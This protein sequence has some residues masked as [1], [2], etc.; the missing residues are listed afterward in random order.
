MVVVV[1]VTNLMLSQRGAGLLP[2]EIALRFASM[3]VVFYLIVSLQG[4]SQ[5]QMALNQTI[6]FTDWVVAHSHLAMM[7]FATFASI[8]GIIHAWQRLPDARYNAKALEWAYWLLLIGISVMMIDLTIAGVIQGKL[9]QTSAPWLESIRVSGPYWLVRSLAAVPIAAGFILVL[10]GLTTGARGAGVHAI[11]QSLRDKPVDEVVP[12]TR[13][14]EGSG[15]QPARA[16]RGLVMSY[17]V[18]SIA[19]V[20]FFALSVSLLGAWPAS[21]L[22]EQSAAMAPPNPLPLTAAEER[23]RVIYAREGCAYCHSQQNTILA[24]GYRSI[25]CT[26]AGLGNT[27]RLP[28][29]DGHASHRTG[30]VPRR[31]NPHRELALRTS[32]RP[33]DGSCPSRSCRRMRRCSTGHRTGRRKRRVTSLPTSSP[34]ADRAN[35]HGR[36]VTRRPVPSPATIAGPV[37][38]SRHLCST[39]IPLAPAPE[40]VRLCWPGTARWSAARHSGHKTAGGCH[41]ATGQGDGPAA[42][43]LT[44]SPTNLTARDYTLPRMSDILWNGVH[45]T[46]MQAWRDL[47]DYDRAALAAQVASFAPG[48]D[49]TAPPDLLSRGAGIYSTHC[50]ECH[51]DDG[52]GNGFAAAELPIMPTDFAGERPTLAEAIGVLQNGVRGTS[53]APWTDRLSDDEITAVAHYVRRFYAGGG[54]TGASP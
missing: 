10:V 23:G 6:H 46:A 1:V 48:A 18:A 25:R 27:L 38:L 51:G 22:A 42:R 17:I 30:P 21:V 32:L 12:E 37:C 49:E 41:G 29:P 31:R 53:M 2:K 54:G 47:S 9:W 52:G 3:S 26:D 7:G 24:G 50:A 35:S 33:S 44:P 20:G 8:A 45:G 11:E 28:A 15:G 19:G 34:W 13:A 5:A 39:R 40:G 16:G 43:W 36:R 14:T 4:A